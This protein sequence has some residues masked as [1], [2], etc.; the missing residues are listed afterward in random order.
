[1]DEADSDDMALGDMNNGDDFPVMS[2]DM[3]LFSVHVEGKSDDTLEDV[4]ELVNRQLEQRIE[5][6][7]D[8][9]RHDRELADEFAPEDPPSR[10]SQ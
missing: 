4:E 5:E 6:V 9:K 1:M 8:L 7:R 10:M 3:R 2:V